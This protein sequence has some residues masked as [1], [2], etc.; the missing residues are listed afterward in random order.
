M[1]QI[2]KCMKKVCKKKGIYRMSCKKH[3]C[4]PG[5]VGT[6]FEKTFTRT[7]KK[8]KRLHGKNVRMTRNVM[9]GKKN[10]VLQKNFYMRLPKKM[11]QTLKKKGA[12]SGCIE[13]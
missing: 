7:F 10:T 13:W 11:R 8:R 6:I 2:K 5:C 12:I 3:Y 9:F 1:N 4:N